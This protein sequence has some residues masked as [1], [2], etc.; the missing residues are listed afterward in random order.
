MPTTYRIHPGVGI[1]R[2]GN[3][4]ARALGRQVAGHAPT[5]RHRGR[6]RVVARRV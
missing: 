3:E 5:E 4:L 6:Q 2:L 1:A